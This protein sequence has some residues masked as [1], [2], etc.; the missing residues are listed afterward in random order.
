MELR[1]MWQDS[2]ITGGHIE[3]PLRDVQGPPT[4]SMDCCRQGIC[5]CVPHVCVWIYMHCC[6]VLSRD[7]VAELTASSVLAASSELT[8]ECRSVWFATSGR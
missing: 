8:C 5:M 1:G 7:Q 3:L 4:F 2:L 6:S